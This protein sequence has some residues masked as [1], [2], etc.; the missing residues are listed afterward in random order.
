MK[1]LKLLNLFVLL[2]G[3]W[4]IL[5]LTKAK[6][7]NRTLDGGKRS[8]IHYCVN[9]LI[10]QIRNKIITRATCSPPSSGISTMQKI[11][12][13]WSFQILQN[14]P[15]SLKWPVLY[16]E[17]TFFQQC[18]YWTLAIICNLEDEIYAV[19]SFTRCICLKVVKM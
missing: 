2:N 11:S 5:L 4:S 1:N 8:Q 3:Q 6:L 10:Y 7:N 14:F 15:G 9:T 13:A 16:L 18:F 19:V 17:Y 12:E